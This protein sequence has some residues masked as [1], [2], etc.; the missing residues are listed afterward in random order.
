[1]NPCIAIIEENTLSCISLCS[2]LRDIYNNVEVLT[3]STM[4]DFIRDSN[5]HYIHFFVDSEILFSHIDEFETLKSQTTVL[6]NT[7]NRYFS[8]AGFNVLDVTAPE[9]KLRSSLL[10]LQFMGQYGEQMSIRNA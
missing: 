2:L 1:M 10:H 3:Y 9:E 4:D 7:Q 6:A 8:D 5:R